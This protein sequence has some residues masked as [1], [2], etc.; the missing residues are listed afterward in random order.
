MKKYCAVVI[1]GYVNGYSIIQELHRCEVDNI[2]LLYYKGQGQIAKYS[3]KLTA[4][5]NIGKGRDSMLH[6]LFLLKEDYDKLVLFPTDDLQLENLY[7]LREQIKEFCFLPFNTRNLMSVLDKKIQYEFCEKLGVP[8]PKTILIE[9]SKDVEKLKTITFPILIKPNKREDLRIKVFR[10]LKIES[11]EGLVSNK[12]VLRMYLEKGLT[13]IASEIVPGDTYGTIYAYTG[14]RS[15]NSSI[16]MNEWIGKKLSQF[17]NDY[18]V[19]SSSSNEAPEIIRQQGRRLLNGMDLYGICEPEFKY[20]FRDGLYKLMEINLRSMMWHRT[21]NLSGVH[22]QYTQWCDSLRL[23][24]NK[25]SQ[26]LEIVHYCY[27]KHEVLNLLFR[28]G[29]FKYFKYNLKYSKMSLALW[30]RKDTLPFVVDQ[31]NTLI[32]IGK[33]IIKKIIRKK[34]A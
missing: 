8:Y 20:D 13:F 25:E 7:N 10:S 4:K 34:D 31:V 33:T 9:Q 16:I 24:A 17:P 21:G 18:G 23:P 2:V 30:D 5:H 28:R 11:E 22:L 29:Y 3:N 14:Y 12:A 15:P 27:L 26:Q 6:R 32:A 19:F 1:G